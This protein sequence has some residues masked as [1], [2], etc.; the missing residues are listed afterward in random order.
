MKKLKTPKLPESITELNET[1][2]KCLSYL[3]DE[4]DRGCVLVASG[5]IDVALE[6]LFKVKLFPT[7][8]SQ[9][10]ENAI[11]S[12]MGPLGA[13][14]ARIKLAYALG[15]VTKIIHDDLNLI[16]AL[17]NYCAH[18]YVG[19]DF[20]DNEFALKVS[21]IQTGK[22]IYNS[23]IAQFP[24]TENSASDSLNDVDGREFLPSRF[25]FMICAAEIAHQILDL[26]R[27]S[28]TEHNV[29]PT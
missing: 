11:F 13:F 27:T 10:N 28:A 8:L 2:A 5:L 23:V 25:Q 22:T 15:Y 24:C 26:I 29:Q 9:D 7:K 19:P 1:Q 14:S 6:S 3:Y 4:S 18:S 16:R 12:P 20:D 17:R 21:A